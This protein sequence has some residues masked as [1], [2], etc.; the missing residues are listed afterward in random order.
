MQRHMSSRV[1]M[2]RPTSTLAS[3]ARGCA[4]ADSTIFSLGTEAMAAPVQTSAFS[5]K[6]L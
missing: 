3:P 4:L 1:L 2:P 6:D 5:S